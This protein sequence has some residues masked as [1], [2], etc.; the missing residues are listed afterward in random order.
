MSLALFNGTGSAQPLGAGPRAKNTANFPSPT[1]LDSW[2]WPCCRPAQPFTPGWNDTRPQH[3]VAN[4]GLAVGF[5]T[6]TRLY[7]ILCRRCDTA[8][9]QAGLI[10]SRGSP[11]VMHLHLHVALCP[12]TRF[13][14]RRRWVCHCLHWQVGVSMLR[15]NFKISFRVNA[16]TVPPGCEKP[17]SVMGQAWVWVEG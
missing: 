8:F 17:L 11:L 12:L 16:E 6:Q 10:A 5:L 15:R 14:N 1:A 3:A 4:T 13:P 7:R 9:T 2:E